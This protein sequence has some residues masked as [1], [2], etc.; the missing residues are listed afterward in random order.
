MIQI[1]L[2]LSSLFLHPIHISKCQMEYNQD[3][4]ALEI[5]VHVYID[6]LESSLGL[7]GSTHLKLGTEREVVNADSLISSYMDQHLELSVNGHAVHHN[8]IGKEITDDFAAF[9][10]YLEVPEINHLESLDITYDA[11]QELYDDQKNI[12]AVIGPHNQEKYYL[13]EKNKASVSFDF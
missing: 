1:V 4:K 3:H 7:A 9:W 11:L 2:F 12:L 6:D 13:S 5:I 8:W 10:C